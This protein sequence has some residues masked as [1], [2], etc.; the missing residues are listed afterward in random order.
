MFFVESVKGSTMWQCSRCPHKKAMVWMKYL[1]IAR[2]WSNG[3]LLLS[4]SNDYTLTQD[5]GG[6]P[7]KY[8][9]RA[10][11]EGKQRWSL[12]KTV[13]GIYSNLFANFGALFTIQASE[14]APRLK[15]WLQRLQLVL[16][17][18]IYVLL[19][20]EASSTVRIRINS[21]KWNNLLHVCSFDPIT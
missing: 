9:R 2:Y 3:F 5:L 4:F 6:Y 14:L 20:T 8:T 19:A 12:G 7:K 15:R 13:W 16:L 18:D 1:K 11:W 21:T 17:L 10:Q